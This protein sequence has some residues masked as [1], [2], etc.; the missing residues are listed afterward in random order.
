MPEQR[1]KGGISFGGALLS[2]IFCFL[3]TLVIL[4]YFL[5]VWFI[6][7]LGI[8]IVFLWVMG[9]GFPAVIGV[10]MGAGFWLW[11]S[12][13]GI[14]GSITDPLTNF[15]H[16]LGFHILTIILKGVGL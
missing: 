3:A 5:S 1:A 11:N 16:G 8:L 7:G 15:W 10:V 9:Y 13:T 12:L 6:L 14:F 2:I 4:T